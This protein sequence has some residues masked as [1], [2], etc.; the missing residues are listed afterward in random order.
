MT[1]KNNILMIIC[2][3]LSAKALKSYGNTYV[4]AP[5]I[6]SLA[7]GGTVFEEAYTPCPLCQPARVSLWTSMYP[8]QTGVLSN[9]P[10]QGFDQLSTDIPT[11]GEVFG[12]SGYKCLHFGKQ[13]DYGSL[14]GFDIR[15]EMQIK[16]ERDNEAINY[17]YE[18]FYDENTTKQVVE[19]LQDNPKGQPFFA[20]ADLQNPHNICS[21]I[22]E[23]EHGYKNF[24]DNI[25]LPLLPENYYFDD[26]ANR[27]SMIQYLCC[28]H[29]RQS[30]VTQW[31]EDDF[32]HYLYAYYYYISL[33][34]K[35]IGRILKA[36]KN[37][38]LEDDTLIVFIADHGEGMASHQLVTKYGTFYEETNHVPMIFKG[39]KV[40]SD[41]RVKG[42]ISLLDVMPTLLDYCNLN[43]GSCEGKSQIKAI[44]GETATTTNDYVAGEWYDE[45]RGYRVPGR[46]MRQGKY[47]YTI[48]LDKD[49]DNNKMVEEEL[50]DMIEDPFEQVNLILKEDYQKV[51]KGL[52]RGLEQHIFTTNDPF[53]MLSADYKDC[54]RNHKRGIKHHTGP[55]AVLDYAATLIK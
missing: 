26:I 37:N 38:Q 6:Q 29:R 51:L 33:V 42:L 23:N 43:V 3:Q 9:L 46:M 19:F 55:N 31:K 48:Y 53:W 24:G 45:F 21:Y 13:H 50:Y 7:D 14:R 49:K 22:G 44:F 54:Y 39:P 5:N 10:D 4:D 12:Q 32:Q 1:D 27:P 2:D 17:D 18:T 15:E 47:K 40:K 16:Q 28:A 52:R 36:L 41:Q 8:H 35:Q 25:V 20:V 30:Q 11:M 34:D